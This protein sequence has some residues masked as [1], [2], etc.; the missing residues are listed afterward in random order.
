[1]VCPKCDEKGC[2]ECDDLGKF[3]IKG[4][5]I[6]YAGAEI[7]NLLDYVALMESGI[8]P[9]AGGS[10]DQVWSFMQAAIVV[11]NE[12]AFWKNKLGI[13]SG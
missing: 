11:K 4:C 12:T 5:P 13:V 2:D 3:D 1:M 8:P 7:W 10:L 6:E 9:V